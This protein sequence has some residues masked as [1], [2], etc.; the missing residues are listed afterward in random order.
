MLAALAIAL[1]GPLRQYIS[2]R[3]QIAST[4]ADIKASQEQL[5][6]LREQQQRWADPSY[7]AEQ[8][9]Q[10][11]HFVEPGQVP[12]ITL[13]PTPTPAEPAS[14]KPVSDQPWYAQLWYSIQGADA[15]AAPTPSVSPSPSP[16]PA[17]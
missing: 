11:L 7:V 17:P 1:A 8:A 16:A 5:K 4:Q 6:S 15:T 12:Y 3:G 2:Q 13:S 14:A 10:R 9:R